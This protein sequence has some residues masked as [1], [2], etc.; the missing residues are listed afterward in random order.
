MTGKEKFLKG[1]FLE[2]EDPAN[3]SRILESYRK[4]KVEIT[5]SPISMEVIDFQMP[6][7]VLYHLTISIYSQVPTAHLFFQET[8][9]MFYPQRFSTSPDKATTR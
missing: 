2:V 9:S 8:K 4:Y 6:T 1:V 3:M 5:A 7:Y